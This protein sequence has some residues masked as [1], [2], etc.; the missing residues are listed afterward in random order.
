MVGEWSNFKYNTH[1]LYPK[2]PNK[3]QNMPWHFLCLGMDKTT[4]HYCIQQFVDY[5]LSNKTNNQMY[6]IR[7]RMELTQYLPYIPTGSILYA[8][9]RD[10]F[11]QVS[12]IPG[13]KYQLTQMPATS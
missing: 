3:L 8:K 4:L 11:Y 6:I 12:D 9:Y 1:W 7:I 5:R 10:L 2:L 13:Q